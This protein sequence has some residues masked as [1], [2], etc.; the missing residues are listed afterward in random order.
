MNH[1][2]DNEAEAV[3]DL[4]AGSSIAFSW[5]Y[6]RYFDKVS[7]IAFRYI[8]DPIKAEDLVQEIF[9]K[10]WDGRDR[11]SSVEK[12]SSYLFS[13]IRNETLQ[14]LK[15]SMRE[16][17]ANGQFILEQGI[18][19]NTTERS[20]YEEENQLL[21][22]K[23]VENLPTQQRKVFLLVREGGRSYQDIA[24][25][26]RLSRNSVR[27]HMHLAI[28]S[29]KDSLQDHL[30]SLTTIACSIGLLLP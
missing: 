26:L 7:S 11:Y 29:I 1:S 14:K 28:K 24:D 27:N 15:R 19:D 12:F 9:L 25:E 13:M 20:M 5:L 18:S 16:M 30:V 10:I 22:E 21:V 6:N 2:Y 23:A 3:R 8:K 4:A 17:A